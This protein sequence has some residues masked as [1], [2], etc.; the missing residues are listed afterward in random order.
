MVN[1]GP[2]TQVCAANVY[3]PNLS[4]NHIS[5]LG[6]CCLLK[7]LHQGLLHDPK[8]LGAQKTSKIRR[9]FG[10]LQ[11]LIANIFGM[12]H[13]IDKQKR[14]YQLRSLPRSMKKIS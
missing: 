6:G 14:R 5:A 11:T 8:N 9:D 10:Q 12:D 3:P 1:F 2:L 7:S 13:A 4:E